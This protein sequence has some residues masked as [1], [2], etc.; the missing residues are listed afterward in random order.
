MRVR[1]LSLVAIVILATLALPVL[2][3]DA[4]LAADIVND[5]GGPVVITGVL[6]YTNQLFTLGVAQPLVILE[7]Q[8][9]FTVRNKGFLMPMESQTMGQFTSDFFSSPVGYSIALP[10]MP[11]GTLSDVDN[12]GQTNL[13]VQI[14][15]PAYWTN[16]FGDPFLEV[17]DLYGGGWSTAYAGTH[18]RSQIDQQD[19]VDGGYYVVYAPDDQQGFPSGFGDDGLLF[20]EDDPIVTLPAGWTV[21]NMNTETFTFDRSREASIDLLEPEGAAL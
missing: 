6:E 20:T 5:E 11:Q 8:A 14:F 1:F 12:N 15:T 16:I 18:F 3:Q 13:G 21:V 7:D 2:A 19:E 9:G 17:R 10:Q 4:P